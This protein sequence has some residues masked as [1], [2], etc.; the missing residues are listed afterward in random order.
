[1]AKFIITESQLR[2][3]VEESVNSIISENE[4]EE[5]FLGNIKSGLGSA[6]GGDVKRA[7]QGIQRG[8]DAVM[9]FGSRMKQG[10]QNTYNNV[11]KGVGQRVD[12][13]KANYQAGQNADKINGVISTLKE[14]QNS[15]VISG[16]KTSATIAELERCLKLGM[17]GMRGRAQQVTDR[18]GK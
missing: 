7:K 10:V 9:D 5:S 15:G 3:I 6:F 4:I 2:Q 11:A 13:F 8:A 1:M 12:A 17:K 18:I 14:L 16:K